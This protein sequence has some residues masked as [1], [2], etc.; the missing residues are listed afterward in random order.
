ML[1]PSA[2]GPRIPPLGESVRLGAE[3][4]SHRAELA[5]LELEEAGSHART[6]ALL[7]AVAAYLVLFTG[8]A[9]TLLVAALVWD[10]PQ[11]GLWLAG[12]CGLYLIGSASAALLLMRRL[13]TWQPFAEVKSQLKQDHQCLSQ[14]LQSIFH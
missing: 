7:A 1:A 11:R 4:L 12:L 14:L 5:V 6:S 13:R 2:P 3:A 8:F 9:F 10:S